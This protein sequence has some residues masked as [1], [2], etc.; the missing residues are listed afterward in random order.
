MTSTAYFSI[1]QP[2][3][4]FATTV[5]AAVVGFYLARL[6][7]P[8]KAR[9]AFESK[10][11]EITFSKLYDKKLESIEGL[12]FHLTALIDATAALVAPIQTVGQR[13]GKD[14]QENIRI[15]RSEKIQ[16]VNEAL[17][18]LY[19]FHSQKSLYLPKALNKAIE[20]YRLHIR[21]M[22]IEFY[23]NVENPGQEPRQHM[24]TWDEAS[25]RLDEARA[26]R[27]ELDRQFREL[28]A[29]AGMES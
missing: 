22:I 15:D 10:Q 23:F 19:A 4:P 16:K 11:K 26:M 13:E 20:E 29:K 21:R 3:V 12:H 24:K 2:L 25:T 1:L 8:F 9:V 17:M 6:L 14:R 7:E 5:T 28:L 27:C 18:S